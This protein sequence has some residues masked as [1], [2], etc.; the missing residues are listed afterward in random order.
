[1]GA[2]KP[3]NNPYWIDFICTVPVES[4]VVPS[5][6]CGQRQFM[7]WEDG[8]GPI[9]R[10][11]AG[12]AGHVMYRPMTSDEWSTWQQMHYPGHPEEHPPGYV[13]IDEPEQP[14]PSPPR[15]N[16][17]EAQLCFNALGFNLPESDLGNDVD[18]KALRQ[19]L[20]RMGAKPE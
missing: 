12:H 20:I 14:K 1:M 18:M 4:S 16:K 13:F 15:L 11:S 9:R 19:K 7:M 17:T 6:T 10:C 8:M 5:A 3:V 2:R